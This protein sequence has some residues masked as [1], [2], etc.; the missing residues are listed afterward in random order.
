MSSKRFNISFSTFNRVLMTILLIWP[1]RSGAT[2]TDDHVHVRMGWAFDGLIPLDQIK[3]AAASKKPRFA[4]WGVH[5]WRGTW[6]VNGSDRGMVELQIDP[7]IHARTVIFA[8][9]PHTLYLSL[10]DPE[11]FIEELG[12]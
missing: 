8:I 10:D 11:G 12:G 9:R 5:G 1:S 2:V 4:G 7:P 6:T 3:S